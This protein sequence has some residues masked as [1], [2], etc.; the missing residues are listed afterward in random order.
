MLESVNSQAQYQRESWTERDELKLLH[1]SEKVALNDSWFI[2]SLVYTVCGYVN[3][4]KL[5]KGKASFSFLDASPNLMGPSSPELHA[6][7]NVGVIFH[8][9]LKFDKHTV[10]ER[11][12]VKFCLFRS[13]QHP[14]SFS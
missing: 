1:L 10:A 2:V 8:C 13:G 7:K 12:A 3:N 9:G 4:S 14:N 6:K 11:T 5:N